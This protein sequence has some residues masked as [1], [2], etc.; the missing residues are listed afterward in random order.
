MS[1]RSSGSTTTSRSG[2]PSGRAAPTRRS[3]RDYARRTGLPLRSLP[4]YRGT[5][6]GWQ[7][8][9]IPDGSAF[10]VELRAGRAPA[11]RH[12]DAVLALARRYA[13]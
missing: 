6:V 3:W 11:K 4:N 9:L 10:V 13:R 12:A 7:N 2:S 1:G 8:Q 5:A